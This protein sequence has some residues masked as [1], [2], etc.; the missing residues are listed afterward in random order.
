M[1]HDEDGTIETTLVGVE[2]SM[3]D[4]IIRCDPYPSIL[5]L[6]RTSP[7]YIELHNQIA[8]RSMI[9]GSRMVIPCTWTAASDPFWAWM[10]VQFT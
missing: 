10:S 8:V 4:L 1:S 3:D 7:D 2:P 9:I 5:I 6:L